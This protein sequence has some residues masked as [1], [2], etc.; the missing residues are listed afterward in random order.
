[1]K[2]AVGSDHAGY[3]L[4]EHV[5]EHL[6][7]AGHE[8]EDVGAH[9]AERTDFPA[10][11]F[12]VAKAVASGE[13]EMGVLVCGTGIGISMAANRVKGA[14]AAN[15]MIEYHVEMARRHNNANI[16]V[17]GERVVAPALAC[18][19]LDLFISTPYDGGRH[20]KR[21]RMLDSEEANDKGE[22]TA[23]ERR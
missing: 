14:R 11:G 10:H 13:F 17:L 2:I 5:R 15:C 22:A 21:V 20:E 19:L 6:A 16:L 9:S 8:V 4:K 23:D 3:A 12:R 1:M 18:R 7:A